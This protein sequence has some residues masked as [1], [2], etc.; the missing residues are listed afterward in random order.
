MHCVGVRARSEEELA[1]GDDSP[2]LIMAC[3]DT[4][5]TGMTVLSTERLHTLRKE[6]NTITSSLIS[7]VE[8]IPSSAKQ[9]FVPTRVLRD[10]GHCN[11]EWSVFENMTMSVTEFALD[12]HW[13][14][15]PVFKKA[16]GVTGKITLQCKSNN[17]IEMEQLGSILG[18]SWYVALCQTEKGSR[19][20]IIG[21]TSGS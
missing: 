11:V 18:R 10:P 19:Q 3:R 5:G 12:C 13:M 17:E 4:S 16:L 7:L 2:S 9:N 1:A 20:L 21:F 15:Q 6:V 8:A 14:L